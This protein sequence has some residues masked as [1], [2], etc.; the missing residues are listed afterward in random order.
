MGG[1]D[2][3]PELS[4]GEEAEARIQLIRLG[5]I[6]VKA[7]VVNNVIKIHIR[8]AQGLRAPIRGLP[9]PFAKCHVEPDNGKVCM[10]QVNR[11]H[12]LTVTFTAQSVSVKT[13]ELAGTANPIW[14]EDLELPLPDTIEVC[15]VFAR[16]LKRA[17][18]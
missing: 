17:R 4:P 5:Q 13:T 18:K 3:E 11:R 15:A 14:K 16:T 9:S 7:K 12:Q 2:D 10:S 8:E 1:G 6:R